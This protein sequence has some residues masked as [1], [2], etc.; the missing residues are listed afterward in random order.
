ML[1]II[2]IKV[3]W[4]FFLISHIFFVHTN[5]Y[6]NVFPVTYHEDAAMGSWKVLL[7]IDDVY[8]KWSDFFGVA[9]GNDL[10]GEAAAI[11]EKETGGLYNIVISRADV[12]AE[13]RWENFTHYLYFVS[14]DYHDVSTILEQAPTLHDALWIPI[15]DLMKHHEN[16]EMEGARQ[17][18]QGARQKAQIAPV[19]LMIFGKIGDKVITA[20]DKKRA[21][22]IKKILEENEQKKMQQDKIVK[23]QKAKIESAVQQPVQKKVGFS[24][25]GWFNTVRQKI[26]DVLSWI[27]NTWNAWWYSKK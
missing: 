25:R 23:E 1:K 10:F 5:S 27:T 21:G 3:L 9:K 15:E 7:K 11:L 20:L 16:D 14:V 2:Q 19:D 13:I 12:R 8:T 24:V 18:A 4:S 6:I 17:T 22:D 26:S